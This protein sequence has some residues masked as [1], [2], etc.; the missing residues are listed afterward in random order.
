[1]ACGAGRLSGSFATLCPGP[2]SG[3]S[4]AVAASPVQ[5]G[6]NRSDHPSRFPVDG[7]SVGC[8]HRFRGERRGSHEYGSA[9]DHGGRVTRG[10]TPHFFFHQ[11]N[12][13]HSCP[14]GCAT[15]PRTP[16]SSF[17]ALESKQVSVKPG[18]DSRVQSLLFQ[19][20]RFEGEI[21]HR[22]IRRSNAN[23]LVCEHDA[24]P[25]GRPIQQLQEFHYRGWSG[26]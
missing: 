12:F 3:C 19:E 2:R 20:R 8:R 4:G 5:S 21:P 24:E 26:G 25:A 11:W 16:H 18:L 22:R 23:F 7:G 15:T 10:Q 13:P 17:Q 1:M 6:A 9:G 14:F